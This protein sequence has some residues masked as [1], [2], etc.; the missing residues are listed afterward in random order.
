MDPETG[1][2]VKIRLVGTRGGPG[3]YMG[4]GK[5]EIV[6]PGGLFFGCGRLG[7][8]FVKPFNQH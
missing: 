8:V 3:R 6:D 2:I 5:S 1:R 7:V 4:M